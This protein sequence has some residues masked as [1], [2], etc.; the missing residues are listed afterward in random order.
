M[1]CSSGASSPTVRG[2]LGQAQRRPSRDDRRILLLARRR[3]RRC[4]QQGLRFVQAP[5]R[6]V[7]FGEAA[8]RFD[9]SRVVSQN[10][11][12]DRGRPG[13]VTFG[14][15]FF[16]LSQQRRRS[17]IERPDKP[18]N[19]SPDLALGQ[20]ADKSVD[21]LTLVESKNGRN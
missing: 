12:I 17:G 15:S 19:E 11:G 3:R 18:L 8:N 20:R 1:A 16:R 21:R 10:F 7:E 5:G 13:S 6:N 4:L 9:V 14:G 2:L